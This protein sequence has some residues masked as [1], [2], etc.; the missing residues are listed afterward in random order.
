MDSLYITSWVLQALKMQSAKM[1]AL[2]GGQGS[3][4][5]GGAAPHTSLAGTSAACGSHKTVDA[6]QVLAHANIRKR[7]HLAAAAAA[8]G[9][10]GGAAAGRRAQGAAA[11]QRAAA[12][13]T[14]AQ[15]PQQ[16]CNV[17]RLLA[18]SRLEGEEPA[19]LQQARGAGAD[20]QQAVD[21][22]ALAAVQRQVGLVAAHGCA[23]GAAEGG[24]M[25]CSRHPSITRQNVP[26][27]SSYTGHLL[28]QRGGAAALPAPGQRLAT[29]ADHPTT[30][31]CLPACPLTVRPLP[32][33]RA[34]R[35][36]GCRAG[37]RRR[38]PAGARPQPRG[39]HTR[40]RAA[41][42]GGRPRRGDGR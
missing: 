7:Q 17:V 15:V 4:S 25:P 1:Q 42:S 35:L 36:R 16:V 9:L 28:N 32:A 34:S 27:S 5:K 19:G 23:T 30:S 24:S 26:K 29:R 37:W 40:S 21:A 38:P 2:Q 39:A 20:G 18:S 13:H 8:A 33:G 3:Y 22:Q 6:A 11:G 14:G 31:T 12:A 10:P 41:A